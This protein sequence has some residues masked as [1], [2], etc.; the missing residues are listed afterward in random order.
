MTHPP[1][2]LTPGPSR[3]PRPAG[4]TDVVGIVL[5]MLSCAG[6]GSFI[7]GSTTPFMI[8]GAICALTV[9]GLVFVA[10]R[11]GRP[12]APAPVAAGIGLVIAVSALVL[13]IRDGSWFTTVG[14]AVTAVAFAALTVRTWSWLRP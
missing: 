12:M 10:G 7:G 6:S 11:D 2:Q 1:Y 8:V 14:A 4:K 9:L 5:G 13:G 3:P